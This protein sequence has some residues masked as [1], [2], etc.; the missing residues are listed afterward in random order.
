MPISPGYN[1]GGGDLAAPDNPDSPNPPTTTSDAETTT[2]TVEQTKWLSIVALAL[3]TLVVAS[4]I[5]MSAFALPSIRRDLGIDSAT[6]AWVLTAYTLPL[7]AAGIPAGRWMDQA[8]AGLVFLL[9]LFAGGIAGVVSAMANGFE[10]LLLGRVLHGVSAAFFLGIYM[11]VIARTVRE[12][13]RGAA[14]GVIGTIMM[15]GAVGLAPLGGLATEIWGW[16]AVFLVKIPLVVLTLALGYRVVP[17][18]PPASQTGITRLPLPDKGFLVESAWLAAAMAALLMGLESVEHDIRKALVLFVTTSVL[19]FFWS[20]LDTAGP[21]VALLRRPRFGL[22]SLALTLIASSIGLASFSLPF[23]VSEVMDESAQVL[24]LAMIGFVG[25]SAVFAP[26]S[27]LLADRVGA[28]FMSMVGAAL[29]VAGLLTLTALGQHTGVTTLIVCSTA[30][31][32]GIATFNT[33]IMT[34]LMVA[35]PAEQSGTA[36]GLAGVTRMVGSTIGPA[37]AALCWSLAGGGIN[38]L[39][40][41]VYILA[42]MAFIAVLSLVAA[43][44]SPR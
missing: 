36:S 25:A 12:N 17:R 10:V 26:L 1:N 35:A 38:G 33:P 4:E 21:V 41:G 15:V 7:V 2:E 22:P 18:Q 20:R 43:L 11:P 30:A 5:T 28:L 40:A 8:D 37:V 34:T 3:G 27:G 16:R 39:H 6:T 29:T 32:A 9:A 24:A 42:G 31:G 14:I 44:R 13:Q 19:L 23:Y